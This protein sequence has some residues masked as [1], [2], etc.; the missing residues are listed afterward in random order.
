MEDF[1][2]TLHFHNELAAGPVVGSV[3]GSVTNHMLSFGKVR[4]RLRAPKCHSAWDRVK[5]P[6]RKET[7]RIRVWDT[8]LLLP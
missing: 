1:F 8:S 3:V 4:A 2:L 5:E 7:L 6:L